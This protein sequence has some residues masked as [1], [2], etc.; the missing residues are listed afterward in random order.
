MTEEHKEPLA[1][2]EHAGL[3]E[4]LPELPAYLHSGYFAGDALPYSCCFCG[5][6]DSGFLTEKKTQDTNNYQQGTGAFT[7]ESS[8]Q[9][10]PAKI[11]DDR[12]MVYSDQMVTFSSFVRGIMEIEGQRFTVRGRYL[13][14]DAI[15]EQW[16]QLYRQATKVTD[17]KIVNTTPTTGCVKLKLSLTRQR[18]MFPI[19][20]EPSRLV[21]NQLAENKST[22]EKLSYQKA[23]EHLAD[24]VLE[25]RQKDTRTLIYASGQLDYF[26]I[27]AMQEVFRLF[28]VR[29]LTGNAEHCLNAG[30]V[31][32]E[33]LT[34]QEGPFLTIDQAIKGE[35]RFYIFNGWN[36]FI[37]HP[38]VFNG[39]TQR[40][41]L[42]AYLIEVIVSESA[43]RLATKLDAER[44]L[45]V[46]P[47]SDPHLA[48]SIAHEIFT[49]YPDAIET[50]FIHQ[51]SDQASF[52]QYKILALSAHFSPELVSARIAPEP[53]YKARL[54]NGIRDIAKKLADPSTVP[55]NIPSVGL[56]QSSGVVT[57]CLWGDM[58][59]MLGKYGLDPQGNALGGTLRVPGQINA[60][61]EVQGLSRK[62]FMGRIPMDK[63]DDAAQRLGLPPNVFQKV[64]DDTP[65]AA[66]D[67]SD[68]T[69][70]TKELFICFGTQF[71]ANMMNRTRWVEKLQDP[72]VTL[73][74]IDP[75]PDPFS[76]ENADLIIP[77]PPHS[78]TTKLYQN[79]EWKMSLSVPQK[80]A[81][82]ETRSDA[83]IIYD[84]MAEVTQRLTTDLTLSQQHSDLADL[85][86]FGYLQQRFGTGLP[87]VDGEVSRPHLWQR[88]QDYMHGGSGPLYC[89]PDHADGRPIQWQE[90]LEKGSVVYGGVGENRYVLDYDRE[91]YQPFA[92]V[93]KKPCSFRFFTPTE[94]DLVIPEGVI[95]N[96]GRSGL[97]DKRERIRFAT[98]SF[99]SGKATPAVDMPEFN[100]LHISP[101]LAEKHQVKTGD[102][103]RVR[104]QESGN[105]M[106]LPVE[107]TQ[108]V[109]GNTTYVSFH[110]SHAQVDKGQ[111]INTVTSHIARC[112]YSA[113]TKV[114]S[115]LI[116]LESL[117]KAPQNQTR[118]VSETKRLDTTFIDSTAAMP[119][120]KGKET[121][122]YITDIIEETHD[123]YTFRFQANPLCRFEYWPGQFCTL[124]LNI[125]GKKVLRSYTISSTPSRPY[126]LEVTIKRVP[127]GLVSNWLPDNLKVGDPIRIAGPKGK[128]CLAPGK[129]PEKILFLTGG[130]GITPLMSMS[131][132]LCD[133][134]ANVDIKFLNSVRSPNDIIYHAELGLMTSRYRI[135]EPIVITSTRNHG[136]AWMGLN[137][138]I[139]PMILNS[140]IPDLHERQIYMCGPEPFMTAMKGILK[141]SN[142]DLANLHTESFGGV[143][144]SNKNKE[145]APSVTP[146]SASNITANAITPSQTVVEEI[147]SDAN[148]SVHFKRSGKTVMTDGDMPLL[149]LAEENDIDLDYSCRSGSCGECKVKLLKGE[150]EMDE[151]E[152]LEP[153]EKAEGYVLSCV[154]LPKGDCE[155][156]I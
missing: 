117:N 92:D 68:P 154:G 147:P 115:N 48:L 12:L 30:A 21:V 42:D 62:Y 63:A 99:N 4:D 11:E 3:L 81:A 18:P 133:V 78:A 104:D 56:S 121:Q 84:L 64:I 91:G 51:F 34:G 140:A 112:P 36:G 41:D 131:R 127:D 93:F 146:M 132:W 70:D 40:K 139:S 76:L 101:S 7:A 31:H 45:L 6:G 65:R 39:I 141:E 149:D 135:F 15:G 122:L 58:L 128:F 44:I 85:A 82:P 17:S 28:G 33:I 2:V 38:P 9:S 57:H 97:S 102:M 88:I 35:N 20:I 134:S 60:E 74:V 116:I 114:K 75:I 14:T 105:S 144:T 73:V 143:R 53:Q 52:E 69:P 80:Q 151:D 129:V 87:R 32:N 86:R 89:A 61:S 66:L 145:T 1:T 47:S 59:A 125:D 24:L 130:S 71:E 95:L 25:H 150:V 137:G 155:V 123:V 16:F 54:L 107:V 77:S 22:R 106:M 26:T 13:P 23:I 119:V 46:K 83:T 113:Q 110:K 108:R 55:I 109:K 96:S 138:R 100:P 136:M 10:H 90:F 142:F 67:Y 5:V 111:Y 98:S 120:W 72:N 153:E 124:I 27:F 43:L 37:T 8:A 156:D 148:I 118:A 152:G 29:N 103:I 49:K 50:R 94:E 19:H 126:V 79:G